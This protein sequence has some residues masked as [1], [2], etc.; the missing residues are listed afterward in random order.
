MFQ[1]ESEV[2]QRIAAALEA[3]LTGSEAKALTAKPTAKVEAH[4][5]YL[6]G[7]YFWN[8]RTVEGF[9]QATEYFSRA[10]TLDPGYAQAWAGFDEPWVVRIPTRWRV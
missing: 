8:K 3:T 9:K 7:R 6:K 10:V 1:V 2:A 5:A 4:E